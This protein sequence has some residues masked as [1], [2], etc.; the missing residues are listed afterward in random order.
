MTVCYKAWYVQVGSIGF[1]MGGALTLSLSLSGKIECGAP[2]YGIPSEGHGEVGSLHL[3]S[4]GKSLCLYKGQVGVL[5]AL[6][7]VHL[8]HCGRQ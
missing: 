2:C 3:F 5:L 4:L 8:T 6:V 7:A 1:C